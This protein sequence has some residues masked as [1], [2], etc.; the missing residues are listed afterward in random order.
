MQGS[1]FGLG[2]LSAKHVK[3]VD[4]ACCGLRV[5]RCVRRACGGV[6]GACKGFRTQPWLHRGSST[7]GFRTLGTWRDAGAE[8][9]APCQVHASKLAQVD[10][11]AERGA[12]RG[13]PPVVLEPHDA[14]TGLRV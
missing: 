1:G 10:A 11:T 3:A 2:I 13:K 7:S 5:A 8:G 4:V 12:D 6:R 9:G 14:L